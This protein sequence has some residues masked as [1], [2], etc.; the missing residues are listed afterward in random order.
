MQLDQ[1]HILNQ[2]TLTMG[3]FIEEVNQLETIQLSDYNGKDTIIVMI[4]M[5]NGFC[6]FGPLSSDFV[7]QMVPK[8]ATFLDQAISMSIP[9]ISYRDAHPENAKEFNFFPQHC[10]AGTSESDLVDE[11]MRPELIDVTKNSTNGFLAQN[12]LDLVDGPAIK[13]VIVIGCVTD[14]CVRD[15]TG[16]FI[17]HLQQINQETQV[18][19][20]ENLVDTF[21]IESIHDRQVEHMLALYQLKNAGVKLARI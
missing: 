15:F 9:I 8:M 4:D 12:P 16:T 1:N 17:K 13:H 2:L 6:K 21:H 20:I 3:S 19:L 5:I 7:N 10:L 14:I 11:L 18:L